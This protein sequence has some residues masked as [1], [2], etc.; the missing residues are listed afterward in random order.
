MNIETVKIQ[1]EG[2]LL[3]GSM[4][5]PN[6]EGNR[7]YQ[8]VQQWISDGNTPEPEFSVAEILETTRSQKIQDI[9]AEGLSRITAAVPALNTF[10]MV[11]F[12][13]EL[14]PSLDTAAL[15]ANMILAKDTYVYAKGRITL[16]DTATQTQLDDYDPSTDVSW[17]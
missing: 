13:Y 1:G 8:M 15:G 11:S 9:K 4:T 7:H 2:W 6:A 17:P 12:M 5:V 14:W 16:A 3:N 10:D